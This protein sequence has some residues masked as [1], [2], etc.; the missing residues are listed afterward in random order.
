MKTWEATV[1]IETVEDGTIEAT[2]T[3]EASTRASA[4]KK[5]LS[6]LKQFKSWT[7]DDL[8]S[9]IEDPDE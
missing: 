9:Y 7:E 5:M 2:I 6:Q 1:L 3:V 4:R 8:D